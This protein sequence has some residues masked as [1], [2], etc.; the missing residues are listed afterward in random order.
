VSSLSLF[1]SRRIGRSPQL[2]DYYSSF[3]AYTDVPNNTTI[4]GAAKLT[5]RTETGYTVGVLDA[6]TN[7]ENGSYVVAPDSARHT[8]PMNPQQ[9]HGRA[10]E[11]GSGRWRHGDW[12][13]RHV[14]GARPRFADSRTACTATRAAG[15]DSSRRGTT[16]TTR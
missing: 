1:Y 6:V 5:G 4:L 10:C 7:Q 8:V 12:R 11:E 9:L 14:D 2:A 13:H 3:A 15:G 16:A